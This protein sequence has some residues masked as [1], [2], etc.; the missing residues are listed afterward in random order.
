[1]LH[2]IENLVYVIAIFLLWFLNGLNGVTVLNLVFTLLLARIIALFTTTI[3]SMGKFGVVWLCEKSL[4]RSIFSY[5]FNNHIGTISNWFNERADQ[6]LMAVWLAPE[7]LG[8]YIVAVSVSGIVRLPSLA[9]S[10]LALPAIAGAKNE[11]KRHIAS[12]YSRLNVTLSFCVGLVLIIFTPFLIP[13]F[14]TDA[15]RPSIILAQVL[16]VASTFTAMST[17]WA[18]ALRGF[19]Q[20]RATSIAQLLSLSITVLGLALVLVAWQAMGAAIVSLVAY[21][22]SAG[23]L[24]SHL[25]KNMQLSFQEILIPLSPQSIWQHVKQR[26]IQPVRPIP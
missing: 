19:N 26:L 11:G 12:L 20:P 3:V 22:V 16:I 15:F 9:I 23:Y 7:Q 24:A 6:M 10:L 17:T 2:V 14:Y 25:L 13:L 8:W 21:A 4:L 18:A 1:V 5:G